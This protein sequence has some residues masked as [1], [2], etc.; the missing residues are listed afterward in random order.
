M[1]E[2]SYREIVQKVGEEIKV[3]V[4]GVLEELMVEERR[5]YLENH[6]TKGNGYYS[7]D[8]L[9][10]YGSLEDLRVPRVREGEFHPVILP[11]RRRASLELSEAIVALYASGVSTRGISKFLEG[12]YGAFYSPQSI[13]RL[14]Q[15]VEEEVKGWRE[16]PLHR[17][18][19]AIYLDAIFLSIRRG[20]SGKEPVYLALGILPDGRREVLGF[21][22]FGAEGESACNWEEVLKDLRERGVEKVKVFVSDDLVGLGG[23]IKKVFPGSEWQLC[24]L[25]MVRNSVKQVRKRDREGMAQ[26]LK[27]I[28]RAE[29]VSEAEEG[30]VKLRDSWGRK[31]PKVVEKW[32]KKAQALLTFLKHPPQ[33]RRYLYT[34]NQLERL[35]K[36]VKRRTKVVEVFVHEGSAEKLLYLVLSEISER[37]GE[38]RL[39][40]FAEISIEGYHLDETH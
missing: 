35:C 15:V 32:E 23:A 17:E 25:H 13:S 19:Y 38:R 31:Y 4:K 26:S 2:R 27:S 29:T 24:V 6:A 9:T 30:L 11:E 22:L 3:M 14:T 39:S 18:Y 34:T 8:L 16:R 37:L 20:K 40:G 28:Y 10:L 33:L 7:R 21:W 12:I 5:M 36:E 1:R